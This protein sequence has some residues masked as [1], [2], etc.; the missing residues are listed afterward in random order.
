MKMANSKFKTD[1]LQSSPSDSIMSPSPVQM[2][3]VKTQD[4]SITSDFLFLLVVPIS[5]SLY[6]IFYGNLF[7]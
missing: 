5:I 7:G 6:G 4:T 3:R 1:M 2:S